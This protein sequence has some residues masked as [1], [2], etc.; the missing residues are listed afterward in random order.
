MVNFMLCILLVVLLIG[1]VLVIGGMVGAVLGTT[2]EQME[3]DFE[4]THK[5]HIK[6]V[7]NE[8]VQL[9]GKFAVF[10]LTLGWRLASNK[11]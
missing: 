9:Y 4:F 3:E 5:P 6:P 11:V 10:F 1:F 2:I 8:L 7:I